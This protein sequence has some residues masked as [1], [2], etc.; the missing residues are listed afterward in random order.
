M[1]RLPPQSL[2]QPWLTYIIAIVQFIVTRLINIDVRGS[3]EEIWG[4]RFLRASRDSYIKM[5]DV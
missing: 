3:W 2:F 5:Y 4:E 1:Y